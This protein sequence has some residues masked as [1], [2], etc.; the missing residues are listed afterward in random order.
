MSLTSLQQY[1]TSQNKI[2]SSN[3]HL[4]WTHWLFCTIQWKELITSSISIIS[5]ISVIILS[6]HVS[7]FPSVFLIKILYAFISSHICATPSPYLLNWYDHRIYTC[8]WGVQKS[9]SSFF[10]S[11]LHYPVPQLPLGPNILLI[12][13]FPQADRPY[14][15]HVTKLAKLW[16]TL[17]FNNSVADDSC[18]LKFDALCLRKSFPTFRKTVLSLS[19]WSNCPSGL[20]DFTVGVL[21]RLN[22]HTEKASEHCTKLKIGEGF[23]KAYP[24]YRGNI[25]SVR[26]FSLPVSRVAIIT[27]IL[28]RVYGEKRLP[29]STFK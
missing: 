19:P 29:Q 28:C 24:F 10:C 11:L 4:S 9:W 18:L 15:T 12:I 2:N 3:N 23:E 22:S 21:V 27:K 8:C 13:F 14:F 7:F 25:T 26:Q 1:T 20:L 17:G 5:W 6:S 16:E